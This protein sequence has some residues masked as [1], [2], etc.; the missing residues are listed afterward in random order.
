[1]R[2]T[3][4]TW[5][6]NVALIVISILLFLAVCEIISRFSYNAFFGFKK[7]RDLSVPA[8]NKFV[9][10]GNPLIRYEIYRENLPDGYSLDFNYQPRKFK[11]SPGP[12][13]FRII[14]IGDSHMEGY[15]GYNL[16]YPLCDWLNNKTNSTKFECIDFGVGGYGLTDKRVLL[17][18]KIVNYKP[19]FLIVQLLDDDCGSSVFVENASVVVDSRFPFYEISPGEII[20][21]SI[22]LSEA[23]NK[24][25]L[26]KSDFY[27]ILSFLVYKIRSGGQESTDTD[28]SQEACENDI[29]DINE[30]AKKHNISVLYVLSHAVKY[31][32]ADYPKYDYEKKFSDWFREM[33]IKYGLNTV[34][35]LDEFKPYNYS[36]LKADEQGHYN[37][38]GYS[39]AN[40]KII[41]EV[42]KR[43]PGIMIQ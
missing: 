41:A 37:S 19:Q 40:K 16:V 31:N 30:I 36:Y 34:F 4:K 21:L 17:S 27:R 18:E 43:R 12:G 35:I 33:N 32:M 8:V 29:L 39:L 23:A 13:I 24:F 5:L 2:K 15:G 1:M 42:V 22:P 38:I 20:P 6:T 14:G 3:H 9:V 10:S 25:L 7:A 28:I 11:A 26:K